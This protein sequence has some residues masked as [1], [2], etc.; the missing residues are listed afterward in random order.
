MQDRIHAL[1]FPALLTILAL[2][3]IGAASFGYL[4]I[5]G[6]WTAL[7]AP[8]ILRA[9][10]AAGLALFCFL[11][12]AATGSARDLRLTALAAVFLY[13]GVGVNL[14]HL[15]NEVW[16][17]AVAL[18][19]AAGLIAAVALFYDLRQELEKNKTFRPLIFCA[20]IL[21]ALFGLALADLQAA[22]LLSLQVPSLLQLPPAGKI[23]LLMVCLI[24][25]LALYG[26]NFPF[27][28]PLLGILGLCAAGLIAS[29]GE[30][31][32]LLALCAAAGLAAAVLLLV[33][34]RLRRN[35][36]GQK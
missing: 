16:F 26:P 29:A 20:L 28:Y 9:A 1:A 33:S 13:G 21:A 3:G 19:C 14:M 2:A 7:D 35:I 10:T 25:V 24:P 31:K 27:L 17:Q 18:T 4:G 22:P 6:L 34:F 5:L 23:A 12:G 30:G 36:R 11:P 8:S 15:Q 32:R